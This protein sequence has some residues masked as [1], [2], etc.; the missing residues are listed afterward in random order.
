MTLVALA[1][2][3]AA[4]AWLRG[5]R[6]GIPRRART[7]ALTMGLL[8]V[9]QMALGIATLLAVVPVSLGVLHQLGALIVFLSALTLVRLLR[10]SQ[11][12]PDQ[13]LVQ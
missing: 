9:G 12:S 6:T 2:V 13:R 10:V 8:A 4:W 3:L 7:A 1:L 11:G 5:S